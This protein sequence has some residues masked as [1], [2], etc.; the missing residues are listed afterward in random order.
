MDL[1][2][3]FRRKKK[4]RNISLEDSLMNNLEKSATVNSAMTKNLID[5]A[6]A[7]IRTAI[8]SYSELEYNIDPFA[9]SYDNIIKNI[10]DETFR[11]QL[12]ELDLKPVFQ[13][14]STIILLHENRSDD[15]KQKLVD[16]FYRIMNE[17]I[18]SSD[19]TKSKIKI[20]T[21]WAQE[22]CI[23]VKKNS[24]NLRYVNGV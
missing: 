20:L 22:S 4:E 10:A 15:D 2:K 12:T 18:A 16:G 7:N 21:R 13:A 11:K 19:S 8:S 24:E 1:F 14:Y 5:M 3:R 17:K 6:S 23:A 9:P